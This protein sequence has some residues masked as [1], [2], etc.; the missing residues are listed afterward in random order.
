AGI[1]RVDAPRGIFSGK[2]VRELF[3]RGLAR[4]VAAP[5]FVGFNACVA[6]D[7]Y[8]AGAGF[9]LA[10]QRLEQGQRGDDVGAIDLLKHV[11]RVFQQVRLGAG[12]KV[13]GVV[14]QG[15]ES[16]CCARSFL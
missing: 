11:E 6:G 16:T 10:L 13:T 15:I 12:A 4:S 3:Q 8:D 1:D 14:D 7:V 2:D 9:Q 5:A